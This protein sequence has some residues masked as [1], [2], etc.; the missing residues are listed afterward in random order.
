MMLIMRLLGKT[1]DPI[2]MRTSSLP[3]CTHD[4]PRLVPQAKPCVQISFFKVN[5]TKSFKEKGVELGIKVAPTFIF[6]KN[7]ERERTITGAKLDDVKG[8]LAELAGEA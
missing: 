1:S 4:Q 6:Y 5:C 3:A 8:A 2:Y 7:G